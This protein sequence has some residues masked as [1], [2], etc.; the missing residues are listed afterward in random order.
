MSFSVQLKLLALNIFT[1]SLIAANV[2]YINYIV[3]FRS[4]LNDTEILRRFWSKADQTVLAPARFPFVLSIIHGMGLNCLTRS[5]LTGVLHL[6]DTFGPGEKLTLSGEYVVSCASTAA[7]VLTG[8]AM[9]KFDGGDKFIIHAIIQSIL[10]LPSGL[11][12]LIFDRDEISGTTWAFWTVSLLVL[13]GLASVF[14][15]RMFPFRSPTGSTRD[16]FER[17]AQEVQDKKQ[18]FKVFVYALVLVVVFSLQVLIRRVIRYYV[19]S[20]EY[21]NQYLATVLLNFAGLLPLIS[22]STIVIDCQSQSVM[23]R[24]PVMG[25]RSVIPLLSFILFNVQFVCSVVF[26]KWNKTEVDSIIKFLTV[27]YLRDL[28]VYIAVGFVSIASYFAV[29][30][31][32]AKKALDPGAEGQSELIVDDDD[33]EEYNI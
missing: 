18:S 8:S 33:Y 9:Y 20:R 28:Y 30:I 29:C 3:R 14:V 12:K 31:R 22:S 21:T 5:I 2:L 7:G 26:G 4:G 13:A 11:L 27:E 15:Q 23:L 24:R 10:L 1:L 19:F 25:W 32:A 6:L 16:P 17:P